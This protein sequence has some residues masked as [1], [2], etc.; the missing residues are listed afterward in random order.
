MTEPDGDSDPADAASYGRRPVPSDEPWWTGPGQPS[1]WGPGPP[2]RPPRRRRTRGG[3]VLVVVLCVLVATMLTGFVGVALARFAFDGGGPTVGGGAPTG[4]SDTSAPPAPSAE[5]AQIASRVIPSIVDIRTNLAFRRGR[6]AG[7]GMVLSSTGE[8]LTN[9]HVISGASIITA[10]IG[11]TGRSYNARVVGFDSADDVAVLQLQNASGLATVARGNASTVKI[12][13]AIVAIG[14]ALGQPGPPSVVS[15]TVRALD[16]HITVA[17]PGS[18]VEEQLSGLIR[19]DARLQPGDSGGPLVDRA[20]RVVGMNTAASI[21]RRFRAGA[22]EG[23]AIPIS[24]A[25]DIAARI[26][27]GQSTDTI[28]IGQPAFLGVE[29]VAPSQ[30]RAAIRNY[31]PPRANGAVVAGV[32]PGTP[33]DA[34]GLNQGDEIVG[35]DNRPVGSPSALHTILASHRPGDR[36]GIRWL[37]ASGRQHDATIQLGSGPPG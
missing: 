4:L 10:Q 27:A 13:D 24:H 14:N 23:Y 2:W 34:A 29:I 18:G 17:D 31:K 28:Q 7:T 25:L 1:A 6:A 35:L 11:G 16:Q 37:D 36:V 32:E 22:P 8:V 21:A 5:A 26:E 15:G 3:L 33:A 9:N 12:G 30:A 19:M 20:G